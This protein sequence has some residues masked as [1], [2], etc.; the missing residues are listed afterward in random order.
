MEESNHQASNDDLLVV[1]V[2]G[3]A[4]PGC[5][6]ETPLNRILTRF[7]R[8]T[9]YF[10]VNLN[11]DESDESIYQGSYLVFSAVICSKCDN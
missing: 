9:T 10:V 2:R 11:V 3:Y 7:Y 8:L 6:N 1:Q 4:D 5:E